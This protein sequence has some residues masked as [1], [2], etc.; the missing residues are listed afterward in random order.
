MNKLKQ[1]YSEKKLMEFIKMAKN[2]ILEWNSFLDE[3]RNK[4][5]DIAR[6]ENKKTK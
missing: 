2:E 4:L 6:K 1:K 3:C 5:V